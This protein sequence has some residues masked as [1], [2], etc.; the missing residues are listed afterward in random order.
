MTP[1]NGGFG[2]KPK[3]IESM[4]LE[5]LKKAG[6]KRDKMF[7]SHKKETSKKELPPQWE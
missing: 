1:N 4:M 3:T 6:G 5:S 2:K 7:L